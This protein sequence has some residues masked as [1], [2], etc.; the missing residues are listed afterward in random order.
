MRAMGGVGGAVRDDTGLV[1]TV[2]D[3]WLGVSA[4]GR[5]TC[6]PR[7]D[8]CTCRACERGCRGPRDGDG[9]GDGNSQSSLL[10]RCSLAVHS[11]AIA[12]SWWP[13]TSKSR[14]V[15]CCYFLRK[16]LVGLALLN[17]CTGERERE[18][19]RKREEG[20]GRRRS[21][22]ESVRERTWERAKRQTEAEAEAE[23]E[24][25]RQRQTQTQTQRKTERR[26]GGRAGRQRP[27]GGARTHSS[28]SPRAEHTCTAGARAGVT[29]QGGATLEETRAAP[30]AT[31]RWTY[32]VG[33]VEVTRE[34]S[35]PKRIHQ[36]QVEHGR[37]LPLLRLDSGE[38]P[39][40][41][42]HFTRVPKAA[43]PR[44]C[45]PVQPRPRS[46]VYQRRGGGTDTGSTAAGPRAGG[47][48][49]VVCVCVCVRVCGGEEIPGALR[50]QGVDG[51]ERQHR[52][53]RHAHTAGPARL[54]LG[55]GPARARCSP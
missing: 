41:A 47:G 27:W 48:G 11:L 31:L 5:E 7:L 49:G 54:G 46:A 4:H 9:D 30:R 2:A 18:G 38:A 19:G 52:A 51:D 43:A 13:S 16:S 23:E 10:A 42:P 44:H 32:V 36:R 39:G 14:D 34:P 3:D 12:R 53:L 28:A 25:E 26:A 45:R 8:L 22:C 29:R 15:D 40:A 37:L 50:W 17:H 21:S 35:V 55:P 6:A 33:R 1:P 24:A 20:G